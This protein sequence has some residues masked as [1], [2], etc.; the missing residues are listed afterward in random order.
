MFRGVAVCSWVR[1]DNEN[2]LSIN[3][4]NQ[5]KRGNAVFFMYLSFSAVAANPI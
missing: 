5:M 2:L 3:G 4:E 1:V